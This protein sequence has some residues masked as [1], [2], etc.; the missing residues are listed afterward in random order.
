[1]I[2]V[3]NNYNLLLGLDFLITIN[4]N[5]YMEKKTIWIRHGLRNNIHLLLLNMLNM[6]Q[7]VKGKIRTNVED[8]IMM[9]EARL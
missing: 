7:L 1:M 3:T 8:A 9:L 5:V 2:V 6:L 4:I